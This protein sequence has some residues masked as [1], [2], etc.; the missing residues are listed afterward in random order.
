[1]LTTCRANL[2]FRFKTMTQPSSVDAVRLSFR[3]ILGAGSFEMTNRKIS[4]RTTFLLWVC[5]TQLFFSTAKYGW[6]T[7]CVRSLQYTR[8]GLT[9]VH[10]RM[11]SDSVDLKC[12]HRSKDIQIYESDLEMTNGIRQARQQDATATD[13]DV[14]SCPM[15]NT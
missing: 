10:I 14:G 7:W 15:H 13:A 12:S 2:N 6:V 3:K 5:R 4:I 8:I 1:M 11:F 9:S